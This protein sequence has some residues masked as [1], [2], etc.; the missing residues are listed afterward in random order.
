M[1][2]EMAP[3]LTD[4]DDDVMPPFVVDEPDA[5]NTP[6]PAGTPAHMAVSA[7]GKTLAAML[8]RAHGDADLAVARAAVGAALVGLGYELE[9]VDEAHAG[10]PRVGGAVRGSTSQWGC[11]WAAN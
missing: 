10:A 11:G 9:V 5:A 2:D 6:P 7:S 4:S 8:S 3:P 1:P